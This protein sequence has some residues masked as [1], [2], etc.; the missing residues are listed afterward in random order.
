MQRLVQCVLTDFFP[1]LKR[2]ENESHQSPHSSAK[3]KKVINVLPALSLLI[4]IFLI[5]HLKD[6][7]KW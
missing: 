5:S 7:S 3:V 1:G 4:H 2:P 6:A